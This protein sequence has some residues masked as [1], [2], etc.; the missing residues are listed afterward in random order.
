MKQFFYFIAMLLIYAIFVILIFFEI[1][2]F[3]QYMLNAVWVTL[4]GVAYTRALNLPYL[5]CLCMIHVSISGIIMEMNLLK[6]L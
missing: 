5:M 1:I 6:I 3:N 4:L 2:T